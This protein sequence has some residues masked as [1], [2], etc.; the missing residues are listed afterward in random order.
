MAYGID[1]ICECE[2]VPYAH[3]HQLPGMCV[4]PTC[5]PCHP[6]LKE[7][8]MTDHTLHNLKQHSAS[9]ETLVA[10]KRRRT[11]SEW[12]WT[13]LQGFNHAI[14]LLKK[15]E[16]EAPITEE[17]L[18]PSKVTMKVNNPTEKT[19]ET[20][21]DRFKALRDEAVAELTSNTDSN[22]HYRTL[23]HENR[24]GRLVFVH[25]N[26]VDETEIDY[27]TLFR[28]AS[29]RRKGRAEMKSHA[30]AILKGLS[31]EDRTEVIDAI[32]NLKTWGEN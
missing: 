20:F 29:N 3:Y 26:G 1:V 8:T 12:D 15:A 13:F 30:L 23:K 17:E 24:N 31:E 4:D 7:T 10:R 32:E 6:E 16:R 19:S 18:T 14:D 5:V 9:I 2:A 11:A 27:P 25:A 28:F 22:N 21:T